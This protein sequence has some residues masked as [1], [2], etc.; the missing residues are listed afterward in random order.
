[1]SLVDVRA[2]A[3]RLDMTGSQEWRAYWQGPLAT[4]YAD[5]LTRKMAPAAPPEP[6]SEMDV[7]PTGLHE[8]PGY[9]SRSTE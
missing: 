6:A 7:Q 5:L 8:L 4:E 9:Y 2:P 3:R 1:M